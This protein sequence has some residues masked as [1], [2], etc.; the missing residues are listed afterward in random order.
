MM[1]LGKKRFMCAL[2]AIFLF[3][4]SFS[5]VYA[6]DTAFDEQTSTQVFSTEYTSVPS[7]WK[8]VGEVGGT[9]HNLPATYVDK[10]MKTGEP[11]VRPYYF[12]NFE[13]FDDGTSNDGKRAIMPYVSK[14]LFS[15]DDKR[16]LVGRNDDGDSYGTLYEYDIETQSVRL[17][18]ENVKC[19]TSLEA[20]VAPNDKVFYIAQSSEIY[21][22]DWAGE[23]PYKK[24][25]LG[26][27]DKSIAGIHVTNDGRYI[28]GS[29]TFSGSQHNTRYDL[30]NLNSKGYAKLDWD[31]SSDF[32]AKNPN[33]SGIGHNQINPVDPDISFLCNEG[34]T[35]FI[36]DRLW[37]YN[38]HTKELYNTFRQGENYD[39]TTAE[40]SGHEVWSENGE[41]LY[42]VKYTN[43]QQKGQNGIVRIPFKP[44]GEYNENGYPV[45]EDSG[46]R[47]YINGDYSYWHMFPSGDNRWCVGDINQPT[48]GY[49][50]K[51]GGVRVAL[52]STLTY[53]SYPLVTWAPA[54]SGSHPHQPHARISHGG[55]TVAWQM[56]LLD[57]NGSTSPNVGVGFMDVTDITLVNSEGSILTGSF[58]NHS[59]LKW[60]DVDGAPSDVS[61][62]GVYQKVTSGNKL[63]VDI[64]DSQV[65]NECVLA[66][67]TVTYMDKGQKPI[68]LVY[69]GGVLDKTYLYRFA[70]KEVLLPK[71]GTN[72]SKTVTVDLGYVNLNNI[73]GHGADM[74]FT[75]DGETTY[76]KSVDIELYDEPNY[77]IDLTQKNNY[78]TIAMRNSDF[79]NGISSNHGAGYVSS[80]NLFDITQMSQAELLAKGVEQIVID[81]ARSSGYSHVAKTSDGSWMYKEISDS[82]GDTKTAWYTTKYVRSRNGG[83]QT[84]TGAVYFDI[85]TPYINENTNSIDVTLTYLDNSTS[86]ISIGYTST[87]GLSSVSID[88]TNTGKWVTKTVTINDSTASM[89]NTETKLNGGKA[90]FKVSGGNDFYL[91]DFSIRVNDDNKITGSDLYVQDVSWYNKNSSVNTSYWQDSTSI[92][93]KVTVVNN[94]D[95]EQNVILFADV[96]TNKGKRETVAV[97]DM[98]QIPA[99]GSGVVSV[100]SALNTNKYCLV[101]YSVF[102]SNMKTLD[103][104]KKDIIQTTATYKDGDVT[105]SWQSFGEGYTYNI[106][107][108]G[109]IIE[110]GTDATSYL[111]ELEPSGRHVYQVRVRNSDNKVIYYGNYVALDL[112]K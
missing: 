64:N 16:F 8:Y 61:K 69:T 66:K 93:P 85:N 40:C 51:Y 65:K 86:K 75:T 41:Y 111:F 112:T 106:H 107:R 5:C 20:F 35:T 63:Y 15:S 60:S 28:N 4:N 14:Q 3:A 31:V 108:D 34:T 26:K 54:Y 78:Y 94:T 24:Y 11:V 2:S 50:S 83:T 80:N 90:D 77:G 57:A 6:N 43:N 47:E 1:F 58:G 18:H 12:I 21:C 48:W 89:Y 25:Y 53:E 27:L 81:A 42:F 84:V 55:Q 23:A 49:G 98:T 30:Q 32:S 13:N 56:S 97:S 92:T 59:I 19:Y 46:E 38:N 37:I 74:Y 82:T 105:L 17:L 95:T 72:T 102:G 100:T 110:I 101:R 22:I 9:S 91:A 96:T 7:T 44:T 68:R 109:E 36:P 99:K 73:T 88:K 29:V 87:Q 76:I 79:E 104:P 103:I 52:M 39:G 62:S 33:S 45:L 71:T 70:D 10:N 67:A